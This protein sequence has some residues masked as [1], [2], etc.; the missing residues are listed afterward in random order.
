MSQTIPLFLLALLVFLNWMYFGCLRESE[1]EAQVKLLKEDLASNHLVNLEHVGEMTS[2]LVQQVGEMTSE[3]LENVGEM[4]SEALEKLE[5]VERQCTS[6]ADDNDDKPPSC[7]EKR[8]AGATP[9]QE[10]RLF[11]FLPPPRPFLEQDPSVQGFTDHRFSLP[12]S[13]CLTNKKCYVGQTTQPTQLYWSTTSKSSG[14]W[15]NRRLEICFW[16]A[17]TSTSTGCI[18]LTNRRSMPLYLELC[19]RLGLGFAFENH[20]YIKPGGS[21]A[22]RR[23]TDRVCV[24]VCVFSLKVCVSVL[25]SKT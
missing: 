14:S 7:E 1:T 21:C 11:G 15:H 25:D 12:P 17:A 9:S 16:L 6:S 10:E 5:K 20:S 22:V 4:R 18:L 3:L 2:K 24:C 8:R 19:V 23:Q 13:P